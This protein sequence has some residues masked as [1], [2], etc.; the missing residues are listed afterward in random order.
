VGLGNHPISVDLPCIYA[1]GGC[2]ESLH[3]KSTLAPTDTRLTLTAQRS[4]S[5]GAVELNI[6]HLMPF[7]YLYGT[8]AF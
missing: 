3:G 8:I 2:L 5:G 1:C 4:K 7:V 6:R